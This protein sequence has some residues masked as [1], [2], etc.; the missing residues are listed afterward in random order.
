MI[1]INQDDITFT[2]TVDKKDT[3]FIKH[4]PEENVKLLEYIVYSLGLNTD[5][6]KVDIKIKS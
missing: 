1:K 4:V 5:S 3:I 6:H 2:V